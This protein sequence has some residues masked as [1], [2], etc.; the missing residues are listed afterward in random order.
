MSEIAANANIVAPA[1]GR[2]PEVAAR[3]DILDRRRILQLCLAGVWLFDAVLQ[4]QA[5]MFTRRFSQ[6]LAAT[7]NGN[8]AVVAGPIIWT[9]RF[10]GQHA[11]VA[12]A[13]FATVQLLLALGIAWRPSVRLALGASIAW[14]IGVW[15]LGEGLGGVLTGAASPLNG[16]PGPVLIYAL[17]AVLLWPARRA[18]AEAPTAVST[19]CSDTTLPAESGATSPS[20]TSSASAASFAAQWSAAARPAGARF[21]RLAWFATWASLAYLALQAAIGTPQSLRETISGIASGE[22][23]WLGRIDHAAAALVAHHGQ[24]LSVALGSTLGIIAIGVFLPPRA[25]RAALVLAVVVAA[26]IWVVGQDFGGIFTGRGTDPG[27]APLLVLLAAAYWP[28]RVAAAPAGVIR[29][30]VAG[31]ARAAA[32][33]RT[34]PQ[35]RPGQQPRHPRHPRLPRRPRRLRKP[36]W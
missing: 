9:A 11:V 34:D 35:R 4:Y 23:G 1:G 36:K 26:V 7:A 14:S 6:M 15:W 21:A 22:R 30:G 20:M 8:P 10:V 5:F 31:N 24:Q 33:S 17:L 13:V 27:S 28:Y 12:N 32:C 25:A 2:A 19:V 16:A 3:G 29:R 18:A